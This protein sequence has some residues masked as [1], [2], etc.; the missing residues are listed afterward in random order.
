MTKVIT[1]DGTEA[2]KSNCRKYNGNYYEIDRQ[3]FKMP[4]GRY[5]RIDTDKIIYDY[6]TRK[7][8][9][10]SDDYINGIVKFED[11]TPVY[12]YFK[13]NRFKNVNIYSIG[14][15]ISEN[16]I[17]NNFV[18]ILHDGRY[19]PKNRAPKYFNKIKLGGRYSKE[20][21][22][23]ANYRL[24]EFTKTFNENFESS[25]IKPFWKELPNITVGIEYETYAGIIPEIKCMKNGLIPVKD[26]SLR[27]NGNISFEYATIILNKDNV[28]QAINEQTKLLNRY[29]KKS[30]NESLH[31][32][33]GG[34]ERSEEMLVALYRVISIVQ[35]ELYKMFPMFMKKTSVFKRGGKNYCK[36]LPKKKLTYTDNETDLSEIIWYLSDYSLDKE[37]YELG[38]KNPVDPNNAHKWNV[39][40]RY[41]ICNLNH[42]AFAGSGTVEFRVHT[43]TFNKDKIAAWLFIT[44]AIVEYADKIKNSVTFSTSITLNDIVD[45]VYSNKVLNRYLKAYIKY[46][47]DL[48][49]YN[50][51][52]HKD[53]IGIL[54]VEND[55]LNGF[56]FP[57][58]E[59]V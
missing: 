54:D 47:K 41:S 36:P 21:D 55:N 38:M 25:N 42:F 51:N 27:R 14:T 32:H 2:L 50:Q 58:K 16:I 31:I 34:Y 15:A 1:Y 44:T 4:N 39:N 11:K 37:E 53:F 56:K 3:C 46:R 26:G 7:Y 28:L 49:K 24:K 23:S 57:V 6:E 35:K 52:I 19:V 43:N 17:N 12:G 48:M 33:V 9:L 29:C 5:Y 59:L 40:S 22:Y 20:L 30:V 18:E 10:R 8:V 45:Q 13:P